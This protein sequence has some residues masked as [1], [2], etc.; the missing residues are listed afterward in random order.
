[1]FPGQAPSHSDHDGQGHKGANEPVAPVEG[2][3]D[4]LPSD[5]TPA[6]DDSNSSKPKEHELFPVQQGD[7]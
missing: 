4:P 3:H 1:M 2:L 7:L 5:S 6:A